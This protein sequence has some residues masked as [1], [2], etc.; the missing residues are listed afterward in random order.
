MKKI[1]KKRKCENFFLEEKLFNGLV[2]KI[3]GA[4]HLL[5]GVIIMVMFTL[6]KMYP[7]KICVHKF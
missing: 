3:F 5:V 6:D 4:E 7:Y 1:N 2:E